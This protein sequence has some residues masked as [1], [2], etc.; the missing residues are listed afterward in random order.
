MSRLSFFIGALIGLGV[1]SA[2][3]YAEG[4]ILEETEGGYIVVN[5]EDTQIIDYLPE[6]VEAVD[7]VQPVN[8]V[9]DDQDSGFLGKKKSKKTTKKNKTNKT[10]VKKSSSKK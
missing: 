6:G 2:S 3:S 8:Q 7:E 5:W 4:L 9:Q 1:L 10:S